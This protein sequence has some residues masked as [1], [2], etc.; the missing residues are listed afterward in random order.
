MDILFYIFSGLMLV[1]AA[2]VVANRNPVSSA[3]LLILVFFFMAGLFVLLEAFFLAVIQVLVYAG[4][5]M[6]LFLFVMML[7]DIRPAKTSRRNLP[8]AMAG[9]SLGL[10]F[11]VEFWLILKRSAL[12][13]ESPMRLDAG[14]HAIG[15]LL[16]TEYLLPFEIT[17]LLLLAALI[18]VVL[19][20]RKEAP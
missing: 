13:A 20:S 14:I 5:V 15:R 3:M 6:V 8:A 10:A 2:M 9:F 11:L 17:S 12:P 18:G 7:L 19:L 1:C 16:F 4:A